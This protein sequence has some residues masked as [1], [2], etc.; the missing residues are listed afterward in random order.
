MRFSLISGYEPRGFSL[1]VPCPSLHPPLQPTSTLSTPIYSHLTVTT[2]DCMSNSCH[3]VLRCALCPCFLVSLP[4]CL[5]LYF[6]SRLSFSVTL[7]IFLIFFFRLVCI[8]APVRFHANS[9]SRMR[10]LLLWCRCTALDSLA[11]SVIGELEDL[12]MRKRGS[13]KS[14]PS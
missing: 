14:S 5:C 2:S 1:S 8:V 7:K 3:L 6:P 9:G 13:R 11:L 12:R 10:V 4:F